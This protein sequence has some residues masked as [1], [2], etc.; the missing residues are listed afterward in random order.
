MSVDEYERLRG[1]KRGKAKAGFPA[2]GEQRGEQ[3]DNILDEMVQ[4][5]E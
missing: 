1:R 5:A 4:A 3:G 2:A